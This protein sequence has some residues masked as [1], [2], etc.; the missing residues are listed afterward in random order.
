MNGIANLKGKM[1]IESIDPDITKEVSVLIDTF[2]FCIEHR[3]SGEVYPTQVSYVTKE[4]IQTIGP[5]NGWNSFDWEKYFKYPSCEVKKI[6]ITG[7]DQIQGLIAYEA[8]EG[9]VHIHLV[10]SAPWNATEQRILGVGPHLFAIACKASF[11]L[12]YDG[13][14]TFIAKSK[15]VGHYMKTLDATILNPRERLMVSETEAANQLVSTYY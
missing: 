15:L 6:T 2:T 11:D 4:D 3:E 5:E 10:E 1:T 7:D 14:V 12:G 9:W 8:R 13:Y